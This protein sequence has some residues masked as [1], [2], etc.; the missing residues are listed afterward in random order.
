MAWGIINKIRDGAVKAYN[1]VVPIAKKT[2][3]I[4]KKVI[5]YAK[6]LLEGTKYG[7]LVDKAE[8]F[9]NTGNKII[10]K[11]EE[12]GGKFGLQSKPSKSKTKSARQA[13]SELEFDDYD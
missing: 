4:G 2:A 3:E 9:V 10:N 13:L 5:D 6:P 12:Y 7:K 8:D 1:T 11:T